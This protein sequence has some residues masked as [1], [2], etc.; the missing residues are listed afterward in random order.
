MPTPSPAVPSGAE[1]LNEKEKNALA[2]NSR[3]I[4]EASAASGAEKKCG[5]EGCNK[6]RCDYAINGKCTKGLLKYNKK[7]H[8]T[9]CH[10]GDCL[11]PAGEESNQTRMTDLAQRGDHA[12]KKQHK[13]YTVRQVLDSLYYEEVDHDGDDDGFVYLTSTLDGSGTKIS[14]ENLRGTLALAR[15]DE[16]RLVR[17]AVGKIPVSILATEGYELGFTHGV[18]QSLSSIDSLAD[19]TKV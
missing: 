11:P 2:E 7:H 1:K 16:R 12:E 5:I 8:N 4:N 15:S 3:K 18:A 14:K 13:M 6:P 17:E 9:T 10:H 19:S